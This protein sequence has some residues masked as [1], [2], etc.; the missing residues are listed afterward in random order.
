MLLT[1]FAVTSSASYFPEFVKAN[2]SAKL[3]F[4]MIF[5][6]PL[7][8]DSSHG[9]K[10][11]IHGTISFEK[12]Q[13]T[14]PQKRNQPVMKSLSFQALPGQTVALVGPSGTGKSTIISMLERFYD[15][16]G[17]NLRIDGKD[18]RTLSLDHLRTQMALVGQEPRLFAG[19][20]KENVC[21]GLKEPASEEQIQNALNLANAQRF[22]SNLPGGVETQVGEKGT[23][24]SGG[25][26]VG[27]LISF[28]ETLLYVA[29]LLNKFAYF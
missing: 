17:G 18:L 27:L 15:V 24:M 7:T 23:Q 12:V 19:T 10:P 6:K 22:I 11:P 28:P 2:S 20:I 21:F 9:D 14:Y 5:H 4:S 25:Q 13:F 8:G 29:K 1:A 26:K 16:S 3:L